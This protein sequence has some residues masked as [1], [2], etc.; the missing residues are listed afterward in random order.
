MKR[1]VALFHQ[2]ETGGYGVSIPD[3]PGF[4]S[5]GGRF[6]AALDSAVKGLQFHVEGMIADGE[7]IPDPRDL[8]DLK[9]DPEFEDDFADAI[10]TL[11]PLLPPRSEP[12]RVNISLE[13]GLVAAID[14]AAKTRGMT[15]SGF[16]AD[17]ARRAL[18]G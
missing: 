12:V 18:A 8:I 7:A 10:V 11:I 15:R 3:F 1:Y 16:L 5:A 2:A 4:I 14:A 9:A 17:A 13:G 6:D